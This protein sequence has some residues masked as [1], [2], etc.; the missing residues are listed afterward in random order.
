M[1]LSV[2]KINKLNLICI[3][4]KY[5]Q[6]LNQIISPL[7]DITGLIIEIIKSGYKIDDCY[8]AERDQY[9]AALILDKFD[10][11]SEGDIKIIITDFDIFIPIFTY[12][13][14]LAKVGGRAAIVSTMRLCNEY[15]GLNK[16][17]QLFINR[18]LKE[19]IH[20]FGHMVNMRHCNNYNCVMASS[21][22]IDDL[23]V[24][25]SNFCTACSE[26]FY[27]NIGK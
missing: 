17:E 20:E 13:F 10:R 19:T 22:T 9:N 11:N 16:D 21:V 14:G 24:K 26:K 4:F 25:S 3:H 12:V 27:K 23:D 15:Y 2:P 7:E 8:N 18:L 1:E 5:D 6:L